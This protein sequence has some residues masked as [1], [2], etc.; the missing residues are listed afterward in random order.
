MLLTRFHSQ[1]SKLLNYLDSIFVAPYFFIFVCIWTYLRHYINLRILWSILTEYS[2]VGPYELNWETQQ[3]KCTLSKWITFS[4]LASL[5][6]VNIFWLFL[7]LRIAY[8]FVS[9]KELDDDRSEYEESEVDEDA[10]RDTV[11]TPNGSA[12]GYAKMTANGH[13]NGTAT[14]TGVNTKPANGSAGALRDRK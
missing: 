8:R 2:E 1:T 13:A 10:V 12:N 5:Q 7:I 11:K 14:T 6:A 9:A 4:L 3:Y